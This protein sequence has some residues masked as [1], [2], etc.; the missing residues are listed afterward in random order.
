MEAFGME[1]K[2]EIVEALDVGGYRPKLVQPKG[3]Y[4]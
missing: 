2:E 4:M 1:H 3:I